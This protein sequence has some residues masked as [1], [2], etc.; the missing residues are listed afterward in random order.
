MQ[1]VGKGGD[2][3]RARERERDAEKER[4]IGERCKEERKKEER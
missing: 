4:N 3:K 1:K 2:A